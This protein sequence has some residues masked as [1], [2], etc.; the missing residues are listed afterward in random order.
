MPPSP[1]LLKDTR[2]KSSCTP[3]TGSIWV[4]W[5]IPCPQNTWLTAPLKGRF[6][7]TAHVLF[8]ESSR[9]KSNHLGGCIS[10]CFYWWVSIARLVWRVYDPNPRAT[11]TTHRSGGARA[12]RSFGSLS[13]LAYASWATDSQT[14]RARVSLVGRPNERTGKKHREKRGDEAET[15]KRVG[16]SED[17]M[18]FRT[19]DLGG[20]FLVNSG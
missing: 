20:F 11:P 10:Y 4:T 2:K 6:T 12:G 16:N 19:E 18:A 1:K 3:Q 13:C 7:F 17:W 14:A 5:G 8:N 9:E 15:G